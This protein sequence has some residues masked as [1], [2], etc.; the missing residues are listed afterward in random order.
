MLTIGEVADRAG[1]ATSALRY[2]EDE[3]LIP[4]PG[5]KSGRRIYGEEVFDHLVFIDLC[6]SAG[7]SISEIRTLK[8]QL[9][10]TTPPGPRLRALANRK[11]G[12]IDEQIA[13]AQRMKAVLQ[14]LMGC[15]C[16]TLADCCAAARASR[17]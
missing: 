4:K 16:P 6:Q 13:T 8:S 9:K 2:Y 17:R 14:M 3:G 11:L 1:L 15:E 5:R 10:K 12:E 7:F